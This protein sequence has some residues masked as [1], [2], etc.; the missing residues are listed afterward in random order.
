MLAWD[1]SSVAV[2][3]EI[4]T[5]PELQKELDLAKS[6]KK[7]LLLETVA[8]KTGAQLEQVIV[9]E[10]DLTNRSEDVRRATVSGD[11]VLVRGE[12]ENT[13][14]YRLKDGEKIGV[15]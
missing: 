13:T 4:R 10:P 5:H 9:P 2:K 8:S 11:M 15:W 14:I 3:S 12:H 6:H 1:L 7:G